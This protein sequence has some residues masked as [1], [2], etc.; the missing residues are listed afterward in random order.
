MTLFIDPL[1]K[2]R[3]FTTKEALQKEIAI[4][5]ESLHL[6][7]SL[8]QSGVSQYTKFSAKNVYNKES[9]KQEWSRNIKNFG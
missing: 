4:L 2:I 1:H 6:G 9:F 7:T 5:H 3:S 8:P